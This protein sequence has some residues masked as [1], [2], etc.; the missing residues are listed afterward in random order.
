MFGF[1]LREPEEVLYILASFVVATTIHEF[2]HAWTAW[3]LGDDTAQRL[4]RITL[5]PAAHFEPIGFLGMVLISFGFPAIGWGKPVPVNVHRLR[6]ELRGRQVGMAVVAGAGPLSNVVQAGVVALPFWLA[7][8]SLA[9]ARLQAFLGTF[10][11]VNLLLAAFNMIP[12]PPLDGSRILFGFLPNFWQP[13]LF[14]LERYGIALI[15]LLAIF[16]RS[17]GG[18]SIVGAMYQPVFDV[19]ARVLTNNFRF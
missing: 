4:G 12:V 6:G 2:M 9:N 15:F 5:N 16:G 14:P 1:G 13:Y 11:F 10:I 8:G 3:Y 17:F 7:G 19:L 18:A